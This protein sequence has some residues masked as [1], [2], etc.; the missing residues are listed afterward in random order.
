M[1]RRIIEDGLEYKWGEL[2]VIFF[3]DASK[4]VQFERVA[5]QDDKL[6]Y[7]N[8]FLASSRELLHPLFSSHFDVATDKP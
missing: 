1:M 4:L 5:V 8:C 6:P 3:D 7:C 2:R